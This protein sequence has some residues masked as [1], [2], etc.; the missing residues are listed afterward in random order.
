ME[1]SQNIELYSESEKTFSDYVNAFSRRKALL[2]W[3]SLVFIMITVVTV[4]LLPAVYKSSAVI[5]IEQQDIPQDLV[6][7]TVTSYA[8]QRIQTISQRVMTTVNMKQI[9]DKYNL[10]EDERKKEPMQVIYEDM[11]DDISLDMISADVFD[12]RTGRASKATIAFSL[13]Y[14]YERPDLTQK[15]ANELV[16]LFLNENLKNRTEMAE[17]ANAFLQDEAERLAEYVL[18]LEN[19]VANF[20]EENADSL[21]EMVSI[22]IDFIERQERELLEVKRRLRSLEERKIYLESELSQL[23]PVLGTF[24]ETG[25]RVMGPKDRLKILETRL[26]GLESRYSENH[27]DIISLKKEILALE[28]QVGSNTSRKEIALKLKQAEVELTSLEENY[29]AE[30]P[31]VKKQKQFINSL[32][33]ELASPIAAELV[34]IPGEEPDNPA[35]IRLESDLDAALAEEESLRFKQNQIEN[36]IQQFEKR[37]SNSPQVEREYRGLLREYENTLLK[38]KEIKAKQM[39][40][41]LAENLESEN[42]GERFTLIEPPLL[43]EKAHKPNRPALLVLGIIAALGIGIG[44]VLGLDGLDKGVYG[45]K[46]IERLVG[47][48]PLSV[49]PYIETPKER[50]RRIM[51]YVLI[52]VVVL[53]I[54]L[55]G[56]LLIHIYYKPL[57]VLWYVIL[58]KLGVY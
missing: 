52:P 17:E 22:N 36:K 41:Q 55:L 3:V 57:D 18:Q 7:T 47:E 1:D 4:I 44:T 16:S 30:H 29:S 50:R 53:S 12:P 34:D 51:M 2:A 28:E 20:K 27:P 19:Q 42:K 10:Y 5:L 21:P 37:L 38:F 25:E 8:D 43:P 35:Y 26:I 32:K 6:R 56:L 54:I 13:S 23:A 33:E 11:R 31:D 24:S 48:L 9:I 14:L 39:E 15:V 45:R 40:A 46:G 58:R 49:I